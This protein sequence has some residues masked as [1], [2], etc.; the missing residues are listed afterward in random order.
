MAKRTENQIADIPANDITDILAQMDKLPTVYKWDQVLNRAFVVNAVEWKVFDNG[1]ERAE[2]HVT[3]LAGS[4]NAVIEVA[5]KGVTLPVGK[6]EQAGM[7]PF[8]C[9]IIQR[10]KFP[11]LA[12]A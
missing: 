3:F 4:E 6:L 12:S 9:K 1:G 10:G 5:A 11:E 7:I 2:L 8:R